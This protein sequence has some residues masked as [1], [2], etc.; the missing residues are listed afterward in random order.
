M[1]NVGKTSGAAIA[2]AVALLFNSVAVSP[3]SAEEAK[4]K[5]MGVNGCKGQSAC[6]TA[7]NGCKGQNACKGQGYKEMTKEECEAA[8]A[9]LKKS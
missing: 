5:C 7:N 4:V 1:K 9:E 8:K 6:G 2:T 3:A